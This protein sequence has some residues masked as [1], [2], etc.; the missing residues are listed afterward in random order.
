M[1]N[2]IAV[3]LFSGRIEDDLFVRVGR[4]YR[5]QSRRVACLIVSRKLRLCGNLEFAGTSS[6][7]HVYF[8]TQVSIAGV[9][10]Q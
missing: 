10:G 7:A 9:L 6:D 4:Y 3:Q 5:Y 1:R 8:T 2:R